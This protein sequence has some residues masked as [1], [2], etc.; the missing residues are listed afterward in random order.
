MAL[1]KSE[2]PGT[3][4][5]GAEKV[6]EAYRASLG[7]D[8]APAPAPAAPA[9]AAPAERTKGELLEAAKAAGIPGR[10][11]MTKEQ[12]AEALEAQG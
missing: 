5:R 10:S 1:K 12:L 9:A 7:S 2:I 6:E 3:V 11:K 4:Q 8:A